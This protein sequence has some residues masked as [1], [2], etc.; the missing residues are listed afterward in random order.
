MTL[1]NLRIVSWNAR[2]LSCAENTHKQSQLIH[3]LNKYETLPEVVC[4]QETWNHEGQKLI[5]LPGYKSPISF[6]REKNQLGGGVAIFIK[7]GIDAD[8][9][10][11]KHTNV[12]IE[13]K[14]IR[15]FGQSNLDIVNYYTPGNIE[16][17]EK[18]YQ[19]IIN[20]I[21]KNAIIV[22]DFNA[23]HTLWDSNF[24]GKNKNGDNLVNF[25]NN[26][27]YVALNTG[28]GT[29]LNIENGTMSAIDLT[30]ATT[31]IS[32]KCEWEVHEDTLGSDHFPTVTKI[33]IKTEY[34]SQDPPPRWKL[35]K[36]DW[37]KFRLATDTMDIYY[38]DMTM[39]EANALFTLEVMAGCEVSIPKTKQKKRK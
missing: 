10:N 19:E 1:S 26:S 35:N 28:Q 14:I 23:R 21:G 18:D 2:S 11:F 29:R 5:K 17:K 8:E 25:L 9:I 4:I 37:E 24:R 34:V 3:F 39:D 33:G 36:A 31:N 15:I 16:I 30:L 38:D 27:D 13:I 12:N 7:F 20:K 6:R 22:G 32:P